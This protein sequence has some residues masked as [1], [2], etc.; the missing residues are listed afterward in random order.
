MHMH[1]AAVVPDQRLGHEGHALA[2]ARA[3]VVQ[4]IFEYLD[5]VGLSDQRVGADADL[6]LPCGRDL[7][8]MHLD[9]ESH[10][11]A[12]LAHR[13][14]DVLEAIDRWHWEIAALDSWT[15][16]FVA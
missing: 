11:F 9:H 8:V 4:R 7:V 6:T 3:H 16:P 15:M 13:R 12:G 14:L 2:I 5:F 10:L 1:A